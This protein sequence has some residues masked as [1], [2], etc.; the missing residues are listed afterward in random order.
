MSDELE[1]SATLRAR[2]ACLREHRL[3]FIL[4]AGAFLAG[5]AGS[6]LAASFLKVSCPDLNS[7]LLSEGLAMLGAAGLGGLLHY[8]LRCLSSRHSRLGKSVISQYPAESVAPKTVF[9]EIDDD[10]LQYGRRFGGLSIGKEWAIFQ[11]AMRI[12]RIRGIFSDVL[13]PERGYNGTACILCLVDTDDCILEAPLPSR[14]TLDRA[15]ACLLECVPDAVS[16]DF[17]AMSDFMSMDDEERRE[18]NRR[19][20]ARQASGKPVFFSYAGPDGVPTSL[21]TERTVED[22]FARIKPG[23][24]LVLTPL[25]PLFLPSGEECLYIACESHAESSEKLRLSA[26]IRRGDAYLHVF[27]EMAGH[28]AAQLFRDCFMRRAIPDITGWDVQQWESGWPEERPVLFVDD[29]RFENTSFE[30]VEAALDGVDG[31]GYGSFCLTFPSG[32]DG[33]LSLNG[34]QGSEYVVE[35]ALPDEDRYLRI[36][37]PRRDQVLFWFSAYYEKAK[38]PYMEEWEDVTKEVKKRRGEAD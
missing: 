6:T 15:R 31:G 27:G 38:L 8:L 32:Y 16:G 18:I 35:A 1:N 11:E 14:D 36:A 4:C 2:T 17:D 19:I 24:M 34:K 25:S 33:Y 12:S 13:G 21:A 22:G 23:D 30:D 29:S 7:T 9:Q 5:S 20:K 28:E 10:I 3:R 37:T 26:Y